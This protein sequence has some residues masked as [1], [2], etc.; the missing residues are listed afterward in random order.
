[1][2]IRLIAPFTGVK[3]YRVLSLPCVAA[4]LEPYGE[5]QI[6]DQNVEPIDDSDADLVGIT[7]FIYNLP[8]AAK[9]AR[10]FRGRGIPV[11]FGGSAAS[12]MPPEL[13]LPHCDS[14]CVGE[15][16]GLGAEIISD[17]K[18]RQLKPVYR[19]PKPPDLIETRRPRVDLLSDQYPKAAFPIEA[20]RGCPNRCAFCVSRFIQPGF[21]PR[22]LKDIERDVAG[23]DCDVVELVDL[24]FAVDK[25]HILRVCEIL[26][27]AGVASWFGE[28]ALNTLDDDEVLDA[29]QRSRCTSV[30]VG[31]ESISE[32]SLATINK[33]FN[34]IQD[35][36]RVLRKIQEPGIVVNSGFV[37]G[38]DGE[39]QSIF[40]RSL[41][42]F[43]R[44]RIGMVSPTFVT[45]LPGTPAY[46]RYQ[47]EGRILT[48]DW[49]DYS[50]VTP[51]MVPDQ[52]S[53]EELRMGFEWFVNRFFSLRS[54]IRRSFQPA[55][56][57][58]FGWKSFRRQCHAYWM[59][60]YLNR[61][62]YLWY[63]RKDRSGRSLFRDKTL[64]MEQV[65]IPLQGHFSGLRRVARLLAFF[66]G[67]RG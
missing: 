44:E 41:E 1:M 35:Y 11:I 26:D 46:D 4:E 36:H 2:K 16:E 27:R 6:N 10:E 47:K 39:D 8:F 61:Y 42:F 25:A 17:V 34:R 54:M 23:R 33:G 60:Q 65:Q 49:S 58:R 66:R 7:V 22:S 55:L 62:W 3:G 53:M 64:A 15:V 13:L 63:V 40:R 12:V 57:L 50:G 30:Y 31:L 32:Q 38:L 52:M 37:V 43:E 45:Y 14:V 28:T 20:S 48:Q 51:I 67:K 21:R 24:N 5:V 9:I 18:R 56:S 29:L 59:N 19:L